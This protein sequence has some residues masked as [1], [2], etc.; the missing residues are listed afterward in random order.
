MWQYHFF[1]L[2]SRL[3]CL[4]PHQALLLLGRGMGHIYYYAAKKQ[5][6][7]A[8][9]TIEERLAVDGQEAMR[10]TQAMCVKLGQTFLEALYMPCLTKEKINRL[11]KID[12]PEYLWD[13]VKEGRGVVLL[14]AHIGNW[15]WLGAGLALNG[16]PLT[17][18]VKPQP[19]EQHTR[20]LNENRE[21]VGIEIFS[22][23]TMEMIGAAK[24]LKAGKI[25]GFLADQDAGPKGLFIPFLG[26]PASTP[27]GPAFFAHKFKAPIVGAFIT[28]NEDGSHQI[29]L[30]PPYHYEDTGDPENDTYRLT[31]RMTQAVEAMIRRYPDNWLW[32]QKRWS[33]PAPETR[34]GP[35][36][37]NKG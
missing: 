21:H 24:A 5:R 31:V 3:I 2:L 17:S 36:H 9:K 12:H 8:E 27:V 32:F 26:K 7:R 15:E 37:E 29:H 22:R 13:A 25:L 10:I 18:V 16:Y 11:V 14:T 1:K 4:L 33:T 20:I 34:K 35:H 23:G 6:L 30:Q 28:R 19:N